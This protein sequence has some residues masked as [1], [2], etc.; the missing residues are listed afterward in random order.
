VPWRSKH[1]LLNGHTRR[2]PLVENRYPGLPVVKATTIV[3]KTTVNNKGFE[4]NHSTNGLMRICDRNQCH[5]SD[6]KLR[7]MTSNEI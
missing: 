5:Y 4:T 2:V 3:W 6:H 7:M 1:P